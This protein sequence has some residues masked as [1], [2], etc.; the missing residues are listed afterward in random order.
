MDANGGSMGKKW[1]KETRALVPIIVAP[2]LPAA[3]FESKYR[4][5]QKTEPSSLQPTKAITTTHCLRLP[6]PWRPQPPQ[7]PECSSQAQC[8]V[9]TA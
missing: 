2:W 1:R 7:P 5:V 9:P 4:D 6:W 3:Q 8:R